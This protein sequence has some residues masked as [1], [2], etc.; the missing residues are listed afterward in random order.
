MNRV[1]LDLVGWVATATFIC[2]YFVKDPQL[3]RRIQ[4]LAAVIWV[5]YGIAIGSAPLIGANVL[6]AA[7][8]LYSSRRRENLTGA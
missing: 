7:L 8:A 6:V 5:G 3:L 4:A 2:S 1:L